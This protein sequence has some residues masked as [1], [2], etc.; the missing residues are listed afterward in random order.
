VT[1]P[2]HTLWLLWLPCFTFLV[3]RDFFISALMQRTLSLCPVLPV[4]KHRPDC[5]LAFSRTPYASAKQVGNH[6][7]LKD[8]SAT[9]VQQWGTE[10]SCFFSL[11]ASSQVLRPSRGPKDGLLH[12]E[13]FK[14]TC[15]SNHESPCRLETDHLLQLP[16]EAE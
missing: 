14:V 10:T 7:P 15:M 3:V 9:S 1:E 6:V 5:C 8:F 4:G 11:W 16:D 13:V 12:G 2:P